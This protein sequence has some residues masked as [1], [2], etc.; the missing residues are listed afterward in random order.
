MEDRVTAVHMLR[1]RLRDQLIVAISFDT[2]PFFL[3]TER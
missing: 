1:G 2:Q 3:V